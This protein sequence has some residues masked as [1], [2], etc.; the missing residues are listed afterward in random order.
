MSKV[1]F[2]FSA[3][4]TSRQPFMAAFHADGFLRSGE[5][6]LGQQVGQR[7]ELFHF[8][9]KIEVL[10]LEI[11]NLGQRK[12]RDGRVII[13]SRLP[14]GLNLY[15]YQV[16]EV[17]CIAASLSQ[18]HLWP[19]RWQQSPALSSLLNHHVSDSLSYQRWMECLQTSSLTRRSKEAPRDALLNA[20]A[21]GCAPWVWE[22]K[23][24]KFHKK[25]LV[26][27][28]TVASSCMYANSHT[29]THSHIHFINTRMDAVSWSLVKFHNCCQ[30][31]LYNF[32]EESCRCF[33][34]FRAGMLV[35]GAQS[36][37]FDPI[38]VVLPPQKR[39]NVF[40]KLD[41]LYDYKKAAKF[42][43]FVTVKSQTWCRKWS[44][45]TICLYFTSLKTNQKI[46]GIW[47]TFTSL[48]FPDVPAINKNQL[49]ITYM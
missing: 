26:W 24:A 1:A 21:A 11:S 41:D 33:R 29:P 6:L 45:L 5:P 36:V 43:L 16:K 47:I 30:N 13:R 10:L 31:L 12:L 42:P 23:A 2:Q 17:F 9:F 14:G 39:W 20:T 7:T 25:S 37:D 44:N 19:L 32:Q 34:H 28:G 38:C 48:H 18:S 4:L 27:G 22:R 49:L 46:A 3:A 8:L 35:N 40:K 15:N